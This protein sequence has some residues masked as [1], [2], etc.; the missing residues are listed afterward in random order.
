MSWLKRL[1]VIIALVVLAGGTYLLRETFMSTDYDTGPDTRTRVVVE[2]RTNRSEGDQTQD[3]FATAQLIMCRL[4]V[5]SDPVGDVEQVAGYVNRFE[6]VLAPALDS[7][8]RKQFKG[9]LEDWVI[10]HHLV[11]VI[12]IEDVPPTPANQDRTSAETAA[13]KGAR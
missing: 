8:D 5:E 2:S 10:D 4:E 1:G 11:D 12:T 7:S 9:C 3:E 13:K 6:V